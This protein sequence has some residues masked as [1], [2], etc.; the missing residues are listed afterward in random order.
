MK[1]NRQGDT[2]IE[3]LF[4]FAI[5]ATITGYAFTSAMQSY[6]SAVQAQN[7]TQAYLLAQYQA[8]GLKTYRDS[9]EW[10]G[11]SDL[12]ASFLDGGADGV[13][14]EMRSKIKDGINPG[15]KFCMRADTQSPTS[16]PYKWVVVND[17]NECN[18]SIA[19]IAPNLK[20]AQVWIELSDPKKS[21]GNTPPSLVDSEREDN[22][23]VKITATITVQYEIPN[24]SVS[25]IV[26]N[27]IFLTEAQ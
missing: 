24:A 23:V 17:T 18:Q 1:K 20:N 6:K 15:E 21:D 9:L 4:A 5:L 16:A 26:T 3:I 12:G 19:E 25:G 11:D 13:I 7:Q 22:D 14:P 10:D 2:L 27:R 8:D